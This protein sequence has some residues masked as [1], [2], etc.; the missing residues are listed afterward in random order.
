MRKPV[1]PPISTICGPEASRRV[2]DAVQ[3]LLDW[4]DDGTRTLDLTTK[5]SAQTSDLLE[6]VTPAGERYALPFSGGAGPQG[7]AGATGPRGYG[8]QY[9]TPPASPNAFNDEFDSGSADL[10]VRGW[11]IYNHTAGGVMSRVGPVTTWSTLLGVAAPTALQ[12]ESTLLASG[13]LMLRLPDSQNISITKT[14]T[15]TNGGLFW[16]RCEPAGF[17]T[18][19][20]AVTQI[21]GAVMGYSSG[22]HLD[23]NN[24]VHTRQYGVSGLGNVQVE[25]VI[26]G[27]ASPNNKQ[28]TMVGSVPLDMYGFRFTNAASLTGAAFCLSSAHGTGVHFPSTFPMPLSS[29]AR[30]GFSIETFGFYDQYQP[31][32]VTIHFARWKPG[33]DQ[34]AW[35]AE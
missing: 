4:I 19:V 23:P 27:G 13:G 16:V 29:F 6:L 20:G 34:Y 17:S 1:A 30:A 5:T 7:P 14:L 21:T 12:Y 2:R 10:A 18:A 33:P 22:G 9:L 26:A 15:F 8:S 31:C 35:I 3:G 24:R 28:Y 32:V 11:E 25:R